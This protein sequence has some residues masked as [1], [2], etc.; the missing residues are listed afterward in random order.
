M[1]ALRRYLD[2]LVHQQIRFFLAG[3]VLLTNDQIVERIWAVEALIPSLRQAELRSERH[4]T[5]AHL[6]R[7][8]GLRFAAAC[9]YSSRLSPLSMISL[10]KYLFPARGP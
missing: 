1:Y 5:L 4:W 2:L 10:V 8:P 9:I 7:H 3:S 6:L